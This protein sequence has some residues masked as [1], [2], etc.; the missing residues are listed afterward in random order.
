MLK[1]WR[2]FNYCC[3][4]Y[5]THYVCKFADTEAG[6]NVD[7]C[8]LFYILFTRAGEGLLVEY[9][10]VLISRPDIIKS[11]IER[12]GDFGAQVTPVST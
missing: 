12:G 8:V 7:S 2:D 4:S 10:A 9:K 3:L 6:R 11:H 1:K 5:L